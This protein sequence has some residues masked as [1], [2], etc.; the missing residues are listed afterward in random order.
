[1]AG[2]AG[3][4]NVDTGNEFDFETIFATDCYIIKMTLFSA[5]HRR[6]T[7]PEQPF[8]FDVTQS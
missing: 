4:K 6:S 7:I 8:Y 3:S 2:S 5:E 1:M